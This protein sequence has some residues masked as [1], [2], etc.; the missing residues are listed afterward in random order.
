MGATLY[1]I[2]LAGA[3][4]A[5]VAFGNKLKVELGYANFKNAMTFF[6]TATAGGVHVDEI[7][8]QLYFDEAMFATANYAVSPTTKLVAEY[9]KNN[10]RD[11]KKA[12]ET[13]STPT[14]V[15][16][17]GI[18]FST[19]LGSNFTLKGD[20]MRNQAYST[21]NTATYGNLLYKGADVAKPNTWGVGLGYTKAYPSASFGWNDFNNTIACFNTS[22]IKGYGAYIDYT[23]AKNI[24]FKFVQTFDSKDPVT[25]KAYSLGEWTRAHVIFNF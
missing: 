22:N 12:T 13:A 16:L 24:S 21:N 4:G 7:P 15:N 18:G 10:S 5:K 20:Y 2:A 14:K 3:D 11:Y 6:G 1:G 23:L 8:G 19:A 25:G 9:L 17:W